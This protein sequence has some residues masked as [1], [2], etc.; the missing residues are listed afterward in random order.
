MLTFRILLIITAL[1]VLAAGCATTGSEGDRAVNDT[2]DNSGVQET[3]PSP[4]PVDDIAEGKK[5]F[6]TN[7]VRCHKEDGTGGKTVIEGKTLNPEDLTAAKMI[8]EP[9]SEYFEH[10]EDGD[11][12][13]GM[14]AFKDVLS[15]AE[16]E[17]VVK[18]IRKEVQKQ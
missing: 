12:E 5:L 15:K 17:Q 8:K 7:C 1:A 6:V 11:E 3:T 14:P 4:A 16:I 18:Y 13:D 9:D 2:A 10:I